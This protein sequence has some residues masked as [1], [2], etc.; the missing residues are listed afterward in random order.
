MTTQTMPKIGSV[1]YITNPWG[2]Y[3]ACRVLRLNTDGS[4]EVKQPCNKASNDPSMYHRVHDWSMH[5]V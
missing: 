3:V 4:I 2:K 1:V 5:E